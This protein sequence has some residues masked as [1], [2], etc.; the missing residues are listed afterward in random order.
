[1]NTKGL[2]F[3]IKREA[4]NVTISYNKFIY[5]FNKEN[6]I[7]HIPNIIT[8]KTDDDLFDCVNYLV[9]S[10]TNYIIENDTLKINIEYTIMA[11][12]YNYL[13][14]IEY[15]DE[16]NVKIKS[17]QNDIK[18]IKAIINCNLPEIVLQRSDLDYKEM[19]NYLHKN[20]SEYSNYTDKQIRTSIDET[21]SKF[22]YGDNYKSNPYY[23][24]MDMIH[25]N[26][27]SKNH[28]V[29]SYIINKYKGYIPHEI[30]DYN[31]EFKLYGSRCINHVFMKRSNIKINKII[32]ISNLI[33]QCSI[34]GDTKNIIN[35]EPKK[36][37][38]V[39]SK[40]Y[41]D[42]ARKSITTHIFYYE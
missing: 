1:M 35:I 30:Y 2:N 42:F 32:K 9:S 6:I 12:K 5:T 18:N 13:L 10:I 4:S 20:F 31:V 15:Q 29:W 28:M 11:K 3:N 19:H 33:S 7:N 14:I 8:I 21:I 16:G 23:L 38:L 37:I 25:L 40:Y 41:H 36:Y 24:H 34:F 39:R 22:L 17:L 27:D 26:F